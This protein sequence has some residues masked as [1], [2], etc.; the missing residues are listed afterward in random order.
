MVY[1]N[2]SVLF[3]ASET[4]SND[5]KI[6]KI[7]SHPVFKTELGVS[8]SKTSQLFPMNRFIKKVKNI[9][10]TFGGRF[11]AWHIGPACARNFTKPEYKQG[12]LLLPARH[13]SNCFTN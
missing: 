8:G 4:C 6:F 9:G 2:Y 11:L 7:F 12:Y 3:P 13:K 1:F 10:N 5:D